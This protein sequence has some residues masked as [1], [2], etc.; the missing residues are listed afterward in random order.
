MK[1]SRTFVWSSTWVEPRQSC[2]SWWRARPPQPPWPPA[3]PCPGARSW[4]P[5]AEAAGPGAG[6]RCVAASARSS[7]CR[8]QGSVISPGHWSWLEL[9]L[10][11]TPRASPCATPPWP[12]PCSPSSASSCQTGG[13]SGSGQGHMSGYSGWQYVA[14]GHCTLSVS[15]SEI[16]ITCK[17]NNK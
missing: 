2:P 1:S 7:A 13:G 6:G 9:Q 15:C 4:R 10:E 16:F 5:G 3:S 17:N 11:L 14:C 8:G 12:G